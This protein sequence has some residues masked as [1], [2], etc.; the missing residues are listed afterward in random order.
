MKI[1]ANRLRD[2]VKTPRMMKD[3]NIPLGSKV[4]IV[5]RRNEAYEDTAMTVG[6]FG[7]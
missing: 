2:Q 3:M 5:C 7:L 6:N 4:D 1:I